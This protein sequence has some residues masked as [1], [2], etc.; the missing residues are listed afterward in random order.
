MSGFKLSI[1]IVTKS[2]DYQRADVEYLQRRQ[3]RQLIEDVW[4][5]GKRSQLKPVGSQVFK[6]KQTRCLELENCP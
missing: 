3:E 6:I 1:S 2:C 4:H 5:I